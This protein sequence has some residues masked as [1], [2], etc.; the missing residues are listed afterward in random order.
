MSGAPVTVAVIEHQFDFPGELLLAT[1]TE[2]STLTDRQL[3]TTLTHAHRSL[4]RHKAA[5]ILHL[6]EFDDRGLAR[7]HG[8]TTTADWAVRTHD[9]SR[10]TAYEY[11]QV[12][13]S[14]RPFVLFTEAFAVGDLSYSKIRLLLQYATLDNESALLELALAHA[15]TELESL[16]AGH[17]RVGGRRRKAGNRLSVTVEPDTG[18]LNFWGSLDPERGAE[19]LAALKAAELSPSGAAPEPEEGPDSSN[20]RFGA[21]VA[22]TRIGAFI[23]M[24]HITRTNAT[25]AARTAPG[26]QVN[27]VIGPDDRAFLPTQPGA[28]SGE[29]LRSILNGFFS[30]QIRD[31]RG[32]VLNL[33]RTSRLAN[34]AQ[35]KVLL[36]RWHFRCATPG[37]TCTRWLE[38]H[39]IHAWASGGATDLDNLIPLC[40]THHAMISNGELAIV[41]D[42]RDPSLLRFR[43]P[44]G[45]S[46]TSE[47]NRPPVLDRAMGQH[48]DSYSHGPVPKGD[49]KLLDV[50]DHQD[51]FDD[52]IP[53]QTH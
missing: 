44:G 29:L 41:V 27:I 16:L 3:T 31:A 14:L 19:F 32:R 33:S 24:F 25:E 28:E 49:E 7:A 48:A 21:P 13:R 8:A 40:P 52:I 15:I 47:D 42:Q 36:T 35:V 12:G 4:T 1:I 30:V 2:P 51:T 6:A 45:E 39:H 53:G 38:F 50:W 10:R 17:D 22:A 23:T 37:C 9:L 43:F 5:F 34:A 20:T 18:R 26:A 46:Y 11:L